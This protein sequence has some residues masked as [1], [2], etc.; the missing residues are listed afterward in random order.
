MRGEREGCPLAEIPFSSLFFVPW[1]NALAVRR[2][3]AL[4]V[5]SSTFHFTGAPAGLTGC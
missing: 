2:V 4:H 1:S 5:A 3:P